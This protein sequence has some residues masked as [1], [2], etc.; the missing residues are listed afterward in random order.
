MVRVH[1]A[2]EVSAKVPVFLAKIFDWPSASITRN[3]TSFYVMNVEVNVTN[4]L[5]TLI[6]LRLN[7]VEDHSDP[8]D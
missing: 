2:E 8:K 5:D 1:G 3:P 4:T 6:R 7:Q